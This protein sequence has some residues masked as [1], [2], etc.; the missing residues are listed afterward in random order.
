MTP[1]RLR[2]DRRFRS[3]AA[4]LLLLTFL[5]VPPALAQEARGTIVGTITDST[6]AVIPG[7][8]VDVISKTMGTKV[9]LTTNESGHYQAAYL[10]PG[11]YQVVAQSDGFKRFIRDGIEVRVND[12]VE[13]NLSLEVGGTEQ[14]VTVTGETPLLNTTSSS[15][16]QVV[17]GR[18]V[19]ELPIPHGNPY[20]LIGLASGVSFTRDPRL[21]RP[22]EP[23][24]I[25]GYSMDG[26]KANRSDVTIDGAPSTATA[27][28]GE[29][30]SSYV[31]PADLV[32]EFKVQTAT[33][34][35]SFGQTEGGVTNISLK[36]GTNALHGTAYYN[37]MAPSLF[38][39]DYFANA[40]RIPRPEFTYNRWG[41]VAGG[42]C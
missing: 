1:L 32:A 37:K 9:S 5:L 33:F 14:S 6:G 40:N 15:L 2:H 39:N 23:T 38:A 31:P 29:V 12:R 17:D 19:S 36:S 22:F 42:P 26:T 18:R 30:I 8:K 10:I 11:E 34:D 28:A 27:N 7:A 16:G 24:H 25:V 4:A 3:A 35:A 21:D 41:G 20:F 13:V